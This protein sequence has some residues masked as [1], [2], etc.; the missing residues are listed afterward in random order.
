MRGMCACREENL[1]LSTG[2]VEAGG[3]EALLDD[4]LQVSQD[5]PTALFG[6]S[7]EVP[8]DIADALFLRDLQKRS[9]AVKRQ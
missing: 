5:V 7:M 6:K 3:V 9:A 8:R 4:R 2:S 1:Q